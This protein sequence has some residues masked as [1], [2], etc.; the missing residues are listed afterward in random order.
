MGKIKKISRLNCDVT[1]L[2]AFNASLIEKYDLL[3]KI[4]NDKLKHFSNN[5][6]VFKL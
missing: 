6:N 1:D 5:K 4:T 2:D 3:K